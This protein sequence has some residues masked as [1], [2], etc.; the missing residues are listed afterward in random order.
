MQQPTTFLFDL[1]GT[2]VDS[3]AD[4]ATAVNLLRHERSLPPLD[5]A[6]VRSYVGDGATA[7]VKR[8]LPAGLFSNAQL[9]RFLALYGEH[10]LDTTRP[11]PGI[12]EFLTRHRQQPLAVV[13]NK[14]HGLTRKL[15]SGLELDHYFPVVVGGDS[16]EEKKPSPVPVRWALERLG[17]MATDAVL[18]GDHHTD[19]S[20]G[21]AAGVRTCF[22]R[23]GLGE[24][25]GIDADFQVDSA[26]ALLQLFPGIES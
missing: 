12:L 8:A 11:Y 3:L 6:A 1:D 25:G 2:L 26:E 15:L 20:A 5:S 24:R 21:Q 19:L 22:C 17:V 4:L 23:W 13:T 9:Q 10:L 18:I 7:L 14:P 16:C